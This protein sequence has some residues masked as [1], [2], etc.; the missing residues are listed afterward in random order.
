MTQ[1]QDK[2]PTVFI[3][4]DDPAIR[5]AMQALMDSV[6]IEHEIYASG[7][8]F[9]EGVNDHRAGC[10]VLDIR[11][12]GLGG[13]ELQDELVKRGS[14][15]PIIFITGHGDVPMAVDAM[16]KGAVDFIQKP[17]RDQDLL[18]RIRE[19]LKTD[20][21]RREEQQKHAE[22]AERLA[23]LT[24]REREVFDLVVTGKPNKVIAYELGVSQRTVEI[25]RARV[26]EK[27]QA[28]SLADLVKMHMTA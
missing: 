23:R 27:M 11:M 19:A 10:L 6:N 8:E 7:D 22:V 24:N 20:Q 4:D 13:L 21:E 18:D 25:H 12:P 3:V 28:R 14:T 2:Q 16:Q 17:F 15:L 5:F 26:M 9:L 1:I